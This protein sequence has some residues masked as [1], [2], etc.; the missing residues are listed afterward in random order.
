MKLPKL[1]AVRGYGA[2][3]VAVQGD[4]DDPEIDLGLDPS[5]AGSSTVTFGEPV[6]TRTEPSTLRVLKE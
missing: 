1:F 6:V 2:A 3:F 4:V 5:R